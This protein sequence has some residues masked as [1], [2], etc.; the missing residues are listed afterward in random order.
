MPDGQADNATIQGYSATKGYDMATGIGSPNI[1]SIAKL[2]AQQPAS[3]KPT[4]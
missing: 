1:G 3:T 4:D 2:L